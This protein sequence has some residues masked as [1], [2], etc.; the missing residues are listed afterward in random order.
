MVQLDDVEAPLARFVATDEG[1]WHPEC[2]GY[3]DLSQPCLAPEL[4]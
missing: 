1:L 3:L 2:R 4:A